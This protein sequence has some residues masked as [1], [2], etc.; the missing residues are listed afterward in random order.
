MQSGQA[1]CAQV[2]LPYTLNLTVTWFRQ[3]GICQRLLVEGQSSSEERLRKVSNPRVA[4]TGW[5]G[6]T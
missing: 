2:G 4:A 3:V 1:G 6:G 5:S